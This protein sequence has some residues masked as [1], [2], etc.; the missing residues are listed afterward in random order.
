MKK[1][2]VVVI[3]GASAG[4][5]RAAVR[6]FAERGADIG[7]VARDRERLEAA[8]LEVEKA[9]GRALVLPT[10]VSDSDQVEAAAERVEKELGP[11]DVW[12]NCAM[13]TIF[14]RFMDITPEE[15]KRATEA[16]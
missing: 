7:L 3:T 5:G 4:L 12:V 1:R 2:E 6:F 9:G 13:T 10:D 16:T 8:R 15:F 14:S 11:I